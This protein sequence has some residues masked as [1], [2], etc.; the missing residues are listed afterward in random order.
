MNKEELQKIKDIWQ[1]S[2]DRNRFDIDW[3]AWQTMPKLIAAIEKLQ[4]EKNSLYKQ[5]AASVELCNI[6]EE[7][8]SELLKESEASQTKAAELRQW[9][10]RYMT[11]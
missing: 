1:E 5:L 7:Q 3:V 9:M 10:I 4:K 11:P 8:I 2:Y 6:R